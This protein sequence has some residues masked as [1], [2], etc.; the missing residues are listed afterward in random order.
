MGYTIVIAVASS[1]ASRN[2]VIMTG[3]KTVKDVL[4]KDY[5]DP[6]TGEA[7]FKNISNPNAGS[8]LCYKQLSIPNKL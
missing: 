5:K 6:E 7:I 1:N 8:L 3:F 2:Y 4:Y